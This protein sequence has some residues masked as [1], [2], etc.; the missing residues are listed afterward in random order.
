M[1]VNARRILNAIRDADHALNDPGAGGRIEPFGDLQICELV[2]SGAETRTL[3]DPTQAGIR[4]TLRLK[5]D[6]GDCTVTT[7]NGLDVDGNTQ[8]VFADVGDLLELISVSHTTG[9]RWEVLVNTGSVVLS[10]GAPAFSLPESLTEY[11]L[12]G[13]GMYQDSGM[14]SLVTAAGQTVAKWVGQRLGTVIT[15]T[16]CIARQ[17]ANGSLVP[18]FVTNSGYFTLPSSFPTNRRDQT[19]LM[20]VQRPSA[21]GNRAFFG[22]HEGSRQ[23]ELMNLGRIDMLT[24]DGTSVVYHPQ[25]PKC[26]PCVVS[27]R[28]S[29]SAKKIGVNGNESSSAAMAA[30]SY[31][32]GNFNAMNTLGNP[33]SG[34][35]LGI[36]TGPLLDDTDFAS[37]VSAFNNWFNAPSDTAPSLN[38][39]CYGDSNTEGTNSSG[40]SW[41]MMF[42]DDG[43]RVIG[44]AAAAQYFGAGSPAANRVENTTQVDLEYRPS[45]G[46]NV[47]VVAFTNDFDQ[48]AGA[49]AAHMARVKSW[50]QARQGVGYELAVCKM[51]YRSSPWAGATQY[52]IEVDSFNALCDSD[53]WMDYAPDLTVINGTG[54]NPADGVHWTQAAQATIYDTIKTAIA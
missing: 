54:L 2:T 26:S 8:A 27:V 11:W 42:A 3:A 13:E 9:Y 40:V 12:A 41:Q 6:G 35:W 21:W 5:T 37:G 49:G 10:G 51:P 34:R 17:A 7:V 18:T 32:G 22:F 47:I 31:S 36:A 52:N 53:P 15:A 25:T 28:C 24:Y 33:G 39:I 14:T 20:A 43:T 23:F 45:A 30:G 50:G 1:S 16:S 38:L 46:K 19:V 44:V 29:A 4:F 48:G